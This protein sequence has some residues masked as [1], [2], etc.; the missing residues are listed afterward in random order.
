MFGELSRHQ[1]CNYLYPLIFFLE[2]HSCSSLQLGSQKQPRA[3]EQTGSDLS[4]QGESQS[5]NRNRTK[6]HEK[7]ACGVELESIDG[8]WIVARG[9]ASLGISLLAGLIKV[10]NLVKADQL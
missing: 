6:S 8:L 2:Q 3:L 1:I 7:A 10:H 5:R 9:A 4:V